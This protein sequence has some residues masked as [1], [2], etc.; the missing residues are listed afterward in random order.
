VLV[1][2]DH[3]TRWRDALPIPDGT[4]A[5]VAQT[6]EDRVFSYLG[7]PEQLHSDQGAQFESKLMK[8]LC[9]IWGVTK[10]RTTPYHA[11]GNGVVERG[12]R[13]LGD[14][15][16]SLLLGAEETD[17]DLMLPHIMR[18]IRATPHH[19]TGETANYLMFGRE[20]KLP[21]QLVYGSSIEKPMTREAYAVKL[22]ERLQKVHDG[23][24]QEQQ[25]I[26]ETDPVGPPKF[27]EGEYV[28]MVNKRLKKGQTAKLAPKFLGPYKILQVYPNRTYKLS[29]DGQTSVESEGRLKTF[30]GPDDPRAEAPLLLE[31]TR[32]KLMMGRPAP[33]PKLNVKTLKEIMETNQKICT[34]DDK[35]Q[36]M[37]EKQKK[38]SKTAPP[39]TLASTSQGDTVQKQNIHRDLVYTPNDVDGEFPCAPQSPVPY[40]PDITPAGNTT[41]RENLLQDHN[42]AVQPINN[43]ES[44]VKVT[45]KS[46]QPAPKPVII[47]NTEELTR[48]AE[49]VNRR[50]KAEVTH[51][52]QLPTE[53]EI[54]I[55][56]EPILILGGKDGDTDNP[57]THQPIA[58]PEAPYDS[59]NGADDGLI[60]T[61]MVSTTENKTAH[62]LKLPKAKPNDNAEAR[63]KQRQY[64][65]QMVVKNKS[66]PSRLDNLTPAQLMKEADKSIKKLKTLPGV[67]QQTKKTSTPLD[68]IK[69]VITK[70]KNTMTKPPVDVSGTTSRI[71]AKSKKSGSLMAQNKDKQA[72]IQINSKN[73]NHGKDSSVKPPANRMTSFPSATTKQAVQTDAQSKTI[74]SDQKLSA[75]VDKPNQQNREADLRRSTRFRQKPSFLRNNYVSK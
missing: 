69:K 42:Y 40:A 31:P 16:R 61:E 30:H 64:Q 41:F 13:D 5:T 27:T 74:S 8:E 48:Q 65:R 72:P 38:K 15:L 53:D 50:T 9:A 36:K 21:D 46:T 28:L 73:S 56:P 19:T 2:A 11:A 63:L 68:K 37:V 32:R 58:T 3:F 43:T 34:V 33:P 47:H 17:W 39:N 14:A 4:A 12:N 52:E 22:Q 70:P 29:R 49:Q 55:T 75:P 23:L 67:Q 44:Q 35:V 26:R 62:T 6:L 54:F 60:D 66:T 51:A 59:M 10:S 18:S 1:V 45:R 7:V 20:L 24:R 57:N 71:Q 25:R